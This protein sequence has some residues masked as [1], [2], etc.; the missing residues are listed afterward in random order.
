MIRSDRV[1]R[2]F[3]PF[4]QKFGSIFKYYQVI[5]FSAVTIFCVAL[6]LT[7]AQALW[8]PIYADLNSQVDLWTQT[9]EGCSCAF[10]NTRKDCACCV[11]EGGCPCGS[12][13][14]HRC[15]Q[16]GIHHYCTHMCNVT[17]E[18]HTLK[19]ES[20]KLFGQIK[21][22]PVQGPTSCWYSFIP[23]ASYRVEIQLYRLISVG[24]YN[25]SRCEGGHVELVDGLLPYSNEDGTQVCG[26]NERFAPPVLLFGDNGP[27]TLIFN[28]GQET[29]RSQMMAFFS[30]T[31]VTTNHSPGFRP[32]GGSHFDG[33]ECDWAYEE[34][35]CRVTGCEIASPG[36]PGLYPPNSRCLYHVT[37]LHSTIVKLSF[38]ALHLPHNHCKTDFVKIYGGSTT[39][40]PL[41]A[42]LCGNKK[43][44]VEHEGPHI[45]IEFSSGSS[46]HPFDY[47]GFVI[48]LEFRNTADATA[49]VSTTTLKPPVP[50]NTAKLDGNQLK[51][52]CGV[53]F[54]GNDTRSG[55]FDSRSYQW[56]HNCTIL[57]I[58]R[59][60]DV[61][62][63]SII[64]Y[65]LRGANCHTSVEI[66]S[67]YPFDHERPIKKICSPAKKHTHNT[68][69]APVAQMYLSP[70]NILALFLRKS[71]IESTEP[72]FIDGAFMFHDE[73][74][75]GTLEPATLCDVEFHGG[76]SSQTGHI[77]N[78]SNSHLFWNLQSHLKCSQTFYPTNNQSIAIEV[79][80][81]HRLP[82][83]V[84]C[85]TACGDGGCRCVPNEGHLSSVSH[86]ILSSLQGTPL[87]C[88]CGDFQQQWLPVGLRSWVPITVVYS[89]AR[90]SWPNKG[91]H[92]QADY[93]FHSDFMC[94][95]QIK[96]HHSGVITSAHLEGGN[97]L[98][99]YYY[100]NCHWILDSNVERQL[101]LEIRSNQ[102]RPC[103]AWNITLHEYNE[104][105]VEKI[106]ELLHTFCPRYVHKTYELPWKL[107]IIVVRLNAM[108]RMLPEFSF[109]WRSQIVRT[110]T[111]L[112]GVIPAESS[113]SY[114]SYLRIDAGYWLLTVIILADTMAF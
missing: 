91:F 66:H 110:N 102:S 109:K 81:L 80:S 63:L 30:F 8:T 59:V 6:E 50:H 97:Q 40:S 12:K 18:A 107:N 16:C 61:V 19:L 33:T 55:H 111:K 13:A 113:S 7:S 46:V 93:T 108:T 32:F 104:I 67:K 41:L 9:A 92:F 99:Y 68:A 65:H 5:V 3:I 85:Q 78:P 112:A 31:Q 70:E 35:K 64:N 34:Q 58:G 1:N 79:V 87:S 60:Y 114:I 103:T 49:A 53:T 88:L 36:Y 52:P 57:F 45:L 43:Q 56:K 21:S 51:S 15:A 74:V 42:T 96:N 44:D 100:Q 27:A 38:R 48:S 105:N 22:P 14:P 54:F 39:N 76:R 47:S 98:N 62:H 106:G 75:E 72:E 37:T 28:V 77:R 23:E 86:L 29:V 82:L 73:E 26:T 24:R 94:G 25:G 17:L 71:N 90:N 101:T 20:G 83:A 69:V 89:L 10:D 84:D 95:Y 11:Q 4:L 2:K